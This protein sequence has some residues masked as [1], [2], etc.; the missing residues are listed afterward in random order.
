MVKATP[1]VPHLHIPGF[2]WE[3]DFPEPT[4]RAEAEQRY[5]TTLAEMRVIE[6]QLSNRN[7]VDEYGNRV[8]G[9]AYFQWRNKAVYAKSIKTNQASLL[10]TWIKTHPNEAH[11]L[12][13]KP[14]DYG[15]VRAARFLLNDLLVGG[16]I[17]DEKVE[18]TVRNLDDLLAR[19]RA[20]PG[21]SLAP[22]DAS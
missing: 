3:P 6:S 16:V 11:I 14:S 7:L 19:M 17:D 4:T 18:R 21:S 20:I 5:A 13:Q 22:E 12:A 8:S 15:V 10:K 1:T 2:N 9:A